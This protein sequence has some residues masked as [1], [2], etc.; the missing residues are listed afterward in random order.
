MRVIQNLRLGLNRQMRSSRYGISLLEIREGQLKSGIMR[1]ILTVS[2]DL[3][4]EKQ[5]CIQSNTILTYAH[6]LERMD[7][8]VNVM[9]IDVST[10]HKSVQLCEQQLMNIKKTSN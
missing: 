4:S 3:D 7:R 8:W 10:N 9:S 5:L 1:T 2:T 6:D